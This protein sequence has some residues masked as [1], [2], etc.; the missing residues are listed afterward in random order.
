MRYLNETDDAATKIVEVI[1][2]IPPSLAW[3][4]TPCLIKESQAGHPR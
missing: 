2:D 1:G 4:C 3:C